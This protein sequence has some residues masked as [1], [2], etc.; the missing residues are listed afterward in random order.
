MQTTTTNKKLQKNLLAM[1]QNE[2]PTMQHYS[3]T[4]ANCNVKPSL[5][6]ESNDDA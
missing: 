5:D 6:P 2:V 1:L 3:I 4:G